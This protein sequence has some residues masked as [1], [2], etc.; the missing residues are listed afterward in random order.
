MKGNTL[1]KAIE[2][3]KKS[4]SYLVTVT[5]V[6]NEVLYHFHERVEFSASNVGPTFS[7]I[8]EDIDNAS[9]PKAVNG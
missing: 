4:G 3:A 9:R 6:E 8:A 1:H 2:K 5:M 7:Q